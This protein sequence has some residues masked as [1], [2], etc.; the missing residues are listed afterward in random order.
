MRQKSVYE[1]AGDLS[2][3]LAELKETV[4][5]KERMDER[6][7]STAKCGTLFTIYCC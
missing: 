3:E 6:Y 2:R 7:T 5:D 1:Y 4:S